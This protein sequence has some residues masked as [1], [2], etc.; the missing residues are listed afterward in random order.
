MAI[1]DRVMKV[2][3]HLGIQDS[4]FLAIETII[5]TGMQPIADSS[6]NSGLHW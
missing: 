2:S 6:M 5:I 4:I 3:G 1:E